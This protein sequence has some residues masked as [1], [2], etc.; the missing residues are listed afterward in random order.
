VRIVTERQFIAGITTEWDS[1]VE[2]GR[3]YFYRLAWVSEDGER[4]VSDAI[5]AAAVGATA[6]ALQSIVPNPSNGRVEINLSLPRAGQVDLV[7]FD[8]AGREVARLA[9]GHAAAGNHTSTWNELAA[10]GLYFVRLRHDGREL[11]R[12]VH[13]RR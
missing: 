12:R 9:S 3:A 6:F 13:L 11:T 5:F 8:I 2:P 4:A 7:V 1:H 10:P